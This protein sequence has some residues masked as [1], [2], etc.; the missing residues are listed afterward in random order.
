MLIG[1]GGKIGAGKSEIANHLRDHHEYLVVS[2]ADPLKRACQELFLFSDQ[3]VFGTQAQKEAIDDRWGCSPRTAMQYLGTDLLRDQIGQIMPGVGTELFCKRF[4]LWYQAHAKAN[5]GMC[6]VVPD[7]RFPNE[8]ATI[9]KLN[10][11]TLF[12]EREQPNRDNLTPH[13]SETSVHPTQFEHCHHNLGDRGDLYLAVDRL[14]AEWQAPK[15]SLGQVSKGSL[16]R[17]PNG[18]PC[19]E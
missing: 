17:A 10:G 11:R 19:Q 12:V 14:V 5:P 3:Q 15:G 4:E 7:V 1:I 9:T 6:V 2:M 18:S 13:I 8:L 16:G